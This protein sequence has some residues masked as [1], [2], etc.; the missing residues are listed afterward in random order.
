MQHAAQPGKPNPTP[1]DARLLVLLVILASTG[2]GSVNETRPTVPDRTVASV[3]SASDELAIRLSAVLTAADDAALAT[4]PGWLEYRLAIENRSQRD[5]EIRNVKLLTEGG[6]Y[7]DSA[8][9]YDEL[10]KPPDA[11]AEVAGQVA[12]QGIGIAAGQVIPYGGTIVGLVTGAAAA[13]S[14]QEKDNARNAFTLRRIK[15]VELAAGGR[16]DGSAFLPA[17][18]QPEAL[19]IDWGT[20]D[21]TERVTLPLRR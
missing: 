4:D 6:R 18:Q 21:E 7:L 19:V 10:A 11:S 13:M 17:I 16:L 3:Q 1:L 20:G 2:C 5:I 15:D 12:R 8:R 9:D 14:A